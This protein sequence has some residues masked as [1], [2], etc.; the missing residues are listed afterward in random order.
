MR[1]HT[2][3]PTHTAGSSTH[4]LPYSTPKKRENA[5]IR[6]TAHNYSDDGP[7]QRKVS[8]DRWAKSD[9]TEP[10]RTE[11][12]LTIISPTTGDIFCQREASTLAVKITTSLPTIVHA[13]HA[14]F[15]TCVIG[16]SSDFGL[17]LVPLRSYR[18]NQLEQAK[19]RSG[20]QTRKYDT[21][22]LRIAYL[23]EPL[24]WR[25]ELEVYIP[26]TTNRRRSREAK[27][28]GGRTSRQVEEQRVSSQ[29]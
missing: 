8:T 24:S 11:R 9:Q 1:R 27:H 29:R 14:L 15:S 18:G 21:Q 16:F 25:R 7:Y 5:S 20:A 26:V 28:T 12:E 17:G 22:L 4:N 13:T 2:K 3:R 23:Q 10:K 6:T 19:V